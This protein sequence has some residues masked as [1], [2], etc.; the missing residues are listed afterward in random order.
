MISL[1]TEFERVPTIVGLTFFGVASDCQIV[2]T[3]LYI[4]ICDV[5]PPPDKQNQST[6]ICRRDQQSGWAIRYPI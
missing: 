6:L 2:A 4:L 1:K 3:A 5:T